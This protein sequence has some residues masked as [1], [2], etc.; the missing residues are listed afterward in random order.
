MTETNP[1]TAIPFVNRIEMMCDFIESDV[2]KRAVANGTP[3]CMPP[4]A[5]SLGSMSQPG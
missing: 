3:V 2:V 4:L 5:G 1:W